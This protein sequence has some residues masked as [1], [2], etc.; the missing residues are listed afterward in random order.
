M[1]RLFVSLTMLVVFASSV[2]A[3]GKVI[4]VGSGAPDP[5]DALLIEYLEKWGLTVEP[6]AHD[7]K[8]PVKLDGIDLVFILYSHTH[9]LNTKQPQ[10]L[11]KLPSIITRRKYSQKDEN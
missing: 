1:N 8:H 6:H 9:Q 3:A 7:A 2:M 10:I 4:L 5:K 11:L